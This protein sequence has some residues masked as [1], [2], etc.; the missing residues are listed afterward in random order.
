MPCFFQRARAH[1][2]NRR[3]HRAATAGLGFPRR[4]QPAAAESAVAARMVA[5]RVEAA[6]IPAAHTERHPAA[7]AVADRSEAAFALALAARSAALLDT[8]LPVLMLEAEPAARARWRVVQ[9]T[10]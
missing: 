1:T 3:E 9:K 10:S 8:A 6:T 2:V 5:A 4:V 7:A